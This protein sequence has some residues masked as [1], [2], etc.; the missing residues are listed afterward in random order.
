MTFLPEVSSPMFRVF[1]FLL[2]GIA[3]ARGFAQS[4]I[5]QV[6][7]I[8]AIV[9]DDVIV[10]SELDNRIERVQAQLADAGTRAPPY[11]VLQKQVLERLIIDRL[12]LQVADRTG[13]RIDESTLNAAVADMARKNGLRLREFRD[14]LENDGYNFADFR[15]QVRNQMRISQVRQRNVGDR[16]VVSNRDVDSFLATQAKQGPA[17]NEYHLNH[18]LL[19]LPDG[20]SPEQIAKTGAHAD[21]LL[22]RLREGANFAEMAVAESAGQR[23]LEGGDMGWKKASQLPTIFSR[24]VPAMNVGD[25]SE[26]IRSPSGFHIVRLTE[27]RG[28]DKHI[29]MQTLSRHIL[30]R[31]NEVISDEEAQTRLEQLKLR[32]EGGEDF[33]D[34]ARSHSDDR[35]SAIK[36]GELGWLS[37]G[38]LIPKFEKVADNLALGEVSKPFKTQ[39]GWHI[40]QVME[41]REYD[42]TEEV[43]RSRAREQIRER[44]AEE[45]G[46]AWLRQLRDSAYVEYRLDDQ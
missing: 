2:F 36:G 24:V 4:A 8:V 46:Q 21:E 17:D 32:I 20:A 5:Q 33:G 3:G 25:V 19:A 13:V 23:A 22:R 26:V 40:V 38:D 34:L 14:V 42:N 27:V 11:Q 1:L 9:N 6:D 30:I 39:F 29:V 10:M 35:A 18:I 45:E 41:R 7:R 44:K 12:Q 28:Q 15:A 16:V 37:P 43:M 31:T